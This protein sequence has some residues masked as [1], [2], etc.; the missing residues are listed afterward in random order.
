MFLRE[1]Q[2]FPA[3]QQTY[4]D[5]FKL[6]DQDGSS[7]LIGARNAVYNISLE[8][9]CDWWI[10]NLAGSSFLIGQDLS[11]RTEQQRI[12][13]GS[14]HRDTALCLVK[15]KSEEECSNYIRVVIR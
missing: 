5:H 14:G 13:W 4:N 3:N 1:V 11:E 8:V 6:L 7:L 10:S 2:T 15:G 12:E 9:S